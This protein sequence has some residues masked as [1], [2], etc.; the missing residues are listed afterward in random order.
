MRKT[1]KKKGPILPFF[2]VE[3]PASPRVDTSI[4]A[5]RNMMERLRGWPSGRRI[6]IRIKVRY[7]GKLTQSEGIRKARGEFPTATSA[8]WISASY[9]LEYSLP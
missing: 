4:L 3:G 7:V 8:R 9:P 6:A 1:K 2:Q 5:P